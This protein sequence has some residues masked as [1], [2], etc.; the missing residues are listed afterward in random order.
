MKTG[1]QLILAERRRQIEAE[2]WSPF[3]DDKHRRRELAKAAESYLSTHSSPDVTA[4]RRPGLAA[5]C[6]NWPWAKKWWKPS[7][8]PIRNLV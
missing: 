6:W 5:P 7:A 4:P 1:A 8:D 3:H 2:G